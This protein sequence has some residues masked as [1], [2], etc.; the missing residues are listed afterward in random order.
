MWACDD[1][2]I[3]LYAACLTLLYLI[4]LSQEEVKGQIQKKTKT[5][6]Q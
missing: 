2:S 5:D 4:L 1:C 3:D 6:A